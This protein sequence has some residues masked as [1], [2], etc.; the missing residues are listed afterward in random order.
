MTV[1]KERVK[2]YAVQQVSDLFTWVEWALM[3]K[4][5]TVMMVLFVF[6]STSTF[7][8]DVN[9]L[10]VGSEKTTN[11]NYRFN[12]DSQA[13][14]AAK[15]KTELQ[16]IL[17]GANLGNVNISIED[18]HSTTGGL[19]SNLGSWFH[20][21]Y[22]EGTTQNAFE[23]RWR[24]L[25]GEAGTDWDYV[26]LI[27]DP[28]TLET[29]PGLY[30]YGVSKISQ[31]VA[32]G[33]GETV[34]LMNWPGANSSSS[35]SHYKD[36][37]YRTGRSGGLKVAPAGLAWQE[38][39][40]PTGTTHPTNNGA[41]IAAASLYSR[42]WNKSA[43][44]SYYNFNDTLADSVHDSVTENIGKQQYTGRF[45]FE[46]S[47]G[48]YDYLHRSNGTRKAGGG[49]STEVGL[50]DGFR[51]TSKH[52]KFHRGGQ[53][54]YIGRDSGHHNYGK[55]Y[56]LAGFDK[57]AFGYRWQ[58]E[59][60]DNIAHM[61]NIMSQDFDL[62]DQ[63]I[64]E[65]NT[66]RVIPRRLL[67]AQFY[68]LYPEAEPVPDGEHINGSMYFAA[69]SYMQTIIS[70]RNATDPE[71]TPRQSGEYLP[72]VH[73]DKDW[74]ASKIGYETAWMLSNC[75]VRAPGFKIMPSSQNKLTLLPGA[76]ET[77]TI[78][79]INPPQSDVTVNI[80]VP[81]G[82]SAVS[83]DKISLTFTPENYKIAQTVKLTAKGGF[84]VDK[85]IRIQFDTVSEDE[86]YN[87]LLDKWDYTVT[88]V[89]ELRSV[90]TLQDSSVAIN[91]E[92]S[93]T[94]IVLQPTHGTLSG[95]IPN[96]IYTPDAGFK[97]M[98]RF[99][100]HNGKVINVD[101]AVGLNEHLITTDADSYVRA[102]PYSDINYGT[103]DSLV[104]KSNTY[105]KNWRRPYLR[106]DLS[107]LSADV[108]SVKI[109]LYVSS[110]S[111][112]A[113]ISL[114]L[115]EDDNWQETT[116]THNNALAPSEANLASWWNASA[117]HF[118]TFDMTNI[119]KTQLAAGDK[120]VS[121]YL[122]SDHNTSTHLASKE[123]SNAAF[124]PTL[125]VQSGEESQ[126]QNNAPVAN[127]SSVTTNE[128]SVTS[129]TLSASDADGDA[130]NYS[131][132][133]GP[134]NGTL[135]GSGASRTYSPNSGF[136]GSETFTYKVNDGTDDS[137]TATV[138][139]T[140]NEV[141]PVPQGIVNVNEYTILSYAGSQ[142]SF[143]TATIED[144]GATL[145]LMGNR[146]KAF[147]FPYTVTTSTVLEFDF[148]SSHEGEIHG[149]GFDTD[150]NL[151]SES[152]FQVYGTQP[153]GIGTFNNYSGTA[154]KKYVI[155]VGE[156]FTGTFQY[157]F[158]AMDD[159]NT[160]DGDSIFSN[161]KIYEAE[162]EPNTAPVANNS[163]VTTDQ[164]SATSI[165]LAAS[166][167]D[168]DVLTY[169]I[170][171]GPANGS[172]SG[173]APNFTYTPNPGFHGIDILTFKVNDGT[174]GSNTATVSITV[175]ETGS[176][177]N[178]Y[179]A[180]RATIVGPVIKSSSSFDVSGTGF[181]D[182][183]NA[184]NDYIE[185]SVPA[186]TAGLANLVFGYALGASNRPLRISV[187][188]VVVS[189]S[190]SFPSTG[191]WS[192][193]RE[194]D[195]LQVTLNAGINKIR[196]TAIGSS[197]GNF[198]YLDV[199]T[200]TENTVPAYLQNEAGLVVFEAENNHGTESANGK[201]WT[202]ITDP[203]A[204]GTTAMDAG[205]DDNLGFGSPARMDHR[206][207]FT[208]TGTHYIWIRGRAWA[209][210]GS[211]GNADSVNFGF[212]GTIV[213]TADRITSFN[214]NYNWSKNTMD[215]SRASFVVTETG[216]QTVNLFMRE[217][218]FV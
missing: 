14:S 202:E 85:G 213:E 170:V 15:V 194:T 33:N 8:E 137:N 3:P 16:N 190:Y 39:G 130:L 55:D 187:N 29:L 102:G 210:T 40:S 157:L 36:V 114:K 119:V 71:F 90:S 135:S 77:M 10:I 59:R 28:Y 169:S 171:S 89:N 200:G 110:I 13:F 153:W 177:T 197:G 132:V 179:E 6:L 99:V 88:P 155:P 199:T 49:S 103:E 12:A 149:I 183:K 207:N 18:Y 5:Q 82:N 193:W 167:A 189:A 209:R 208:K 214:T 37:V 174:N 212:N 4:V 138:T 143:G 204:S 63:M 51:E 80:S 148:S 65:S 168:D 113:T 2:N 92:G 159:D 160:K 139:I 186:N 42:I 96:L 69:G 73:S 136:S 196:A 131:I 115:V 50:F 78:Q 121:F 58:H 75:Q 56:R 79:F 154:V 188:G 211:R 151:S 163:S 111:G 129:V 198:D 11:N 205:P 217:N 141:V 41:F 165:T 62:A 108:A 150:R 54:W 126:S 64:G 35:V 156:H 23:N 175:N 19:S 152:F 173:S 17:D 70:N 87:G 125:I 83:L 178:R 86:V 176:S 133:S 26:I 53:T 184:N 91:L 142:D 101:I 32:K 100:Y 68:R 25:R 47:I 118:V 24:N 166:D 147:E 95:T 146:W 1:I 116:I 105:V 201:S 74:M 21:P 52:A 181:V 107:K 144:G 38:E 67:W 158:F 72:W 97:G 34:L 145:H 127:N 215:S 9:I 120:K 45:N 161:V 195:A 172:L 218:G 134:S 164:D 162:T 57:F 140:V 20:Y 7:A 180:E 104:A 191:G 22:Y 109:R 216:V 112:S 182:Y 27:G 123:H 122:M 44:E 124:H 66:F 81:S 46:S 48:R 84:T 185:W 76:S 106:F 203:N 94:G 98:D 117:D 30:S 31:E 206:V 128:G 60:K 61:A 93:V 192:N 43:K